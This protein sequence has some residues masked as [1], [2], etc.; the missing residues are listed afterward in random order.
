M[1]YCRRS[2][3]FRALLGGAFSDEHFDIAEVALE[4]ATLPTGVGQT[5]ETQ[6]LLQR[7]R[8]AS[9]AFAA[10]LNASSGSARVRALR[11]AARG[12][13]TRH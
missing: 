11:V 5:A 9:G 10:G 2:R 6:T 12:A 4:R 3:S 8:F 1:S 7:T 13:A